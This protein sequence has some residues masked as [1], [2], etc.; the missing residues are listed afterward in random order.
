MISDLYLIKK[1]KVGILLMAIARQWLTETYALMIL[2]F[3]AVLR[4]PV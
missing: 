4:K 3:E 1:M 2:D